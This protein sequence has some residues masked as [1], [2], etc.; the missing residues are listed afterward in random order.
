MPRLNYITA[1]HVAWTLGLARQDY[2]DR[3]W[4]RIVGRAATLHVDGLRVSV[5]SFPPYLR[6]AFWQAVANRRI[7]AEVHPD[8]FNPYTWGEHSAYKEEQRQR[9]T[10]DYVAK[11]ARAAVSRRLVYD[12]AEEAEDDEAE[13]YFDGDEQDY[14]AFKARRRG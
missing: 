4:R 9:R 6:A 7:A 1:Q 2:S 3:D 12:S 11:R 14:A 5:L 8:A 10:R 13:Q